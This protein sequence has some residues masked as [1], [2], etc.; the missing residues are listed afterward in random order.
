[1]YKDNTDGKNAD[2]IPAL[3]EVNPNI[4]GIFVV[5][6]DGDVIE[7]GDIGEMVS[8]QSIEKVFAMAMVIDDLGADALRIKLVSMPQV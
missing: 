6:V 7:F 1:M 5:T 8:M 4:F 3:A 2:Y